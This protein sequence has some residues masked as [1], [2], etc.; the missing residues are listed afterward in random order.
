MKKITSR[1]KFIRKTGI[2]SLGIPLLGSQLISCGTKENKKVKEEINKSKKLKIL[3]LG[4]TSF[5]G[6][7]QIAYALNRGHSISTFT[8]GKTVPTVYKNLFENVEQLIGDRENNLKA[9]E[10]KKWDIVID[11]SGQK[12]DWTKKT[13]ELLKENVGTY[14]YISSTG[15]YYPYLSDNINEDTKLLLKEPDVIE[16]EDEKLE[17]WYG[18][19]K[20][21]SELQ[22]IKAFGKDRSLIVRPTY[23]MG[24]ADR[25]DRFTYWPIRLFKGGEVLVPGKTNDPVQYIDVRDVAEFTIRLAEEKL[26]GTFNAVGPKHSQTMT[27]FVNEAKEA[28]D[29]KSTLVR[30]DNYDFLKENGIPYLVPWIMPEG[31][32]Y[33][34]S[35]A[36]N[37]KAINAGLTFRPLKISMKDIYQWWN[38][39]ALTDK[40]RAKL[41]ADPNGLL[42]REKSIIEKWK[43]LKK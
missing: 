3:I 40:R 37:S 14:V 6:P 19:M 16:N 33:G 17:Y 8:R 15:V 9:L 30:I 36:T 35:R 20:A 39:D 29:V 28:F 41:E 26:A 12:V 38:S 34:S 42:M 18:V 32:N 43:N 5:L 31:K 27:E 22:V 2:M 25:T 13:V 21:K 1:R 23:M 11:N 10:N 24:P 7:H 4:G